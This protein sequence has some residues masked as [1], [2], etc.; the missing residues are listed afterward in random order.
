MG[1]EEKAVEIKAE[2]LLQEENAIQKL[3]QNAEKFYTKNLFGLWLLSVLV[4]YNIGFD[5]ATFI[6]FKIP[7]LILLTGAYAYQEVSQIHKR[8][9]AVLKLLRYEKKKDS[10]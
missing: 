6:G 9:D 10:E 8:I 7:I 1:Q 5:N 3:R 4:V 2:F